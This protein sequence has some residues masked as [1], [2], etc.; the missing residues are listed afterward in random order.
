MILFGQVL[1]GPEAARLGLAWESVTPETLLDRSIEIAARAASGP[2]ELVA[3]IKKTLR[4]MGRITT[5][6]D[7]V[8]RE[9]H[10]Q[11]DSINQPAFQERLAA[12]KAKI[13]G[14]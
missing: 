13:T 10:P 6:A 7:A 12:L 14:S 4:D 1:S 8:E 3:E 11:V 5:H 2:R 9:L